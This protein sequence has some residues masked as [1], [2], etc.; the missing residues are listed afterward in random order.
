MSS[1]RSRGRL[2]ACATATVT[3]LLAACGSTATSPDGDGSRVVRALAG[4]TSAPAVTK[5]WA[6]WPQALHDAQHSGASA[7]VGPRSGHVRWTR[8]LEGD[9]TP[10][11]VVG[12][13]GTVYAASNAGVLHALDPATGKDRWRVDEHAGYG[14]DL[15]TSPAVLPNGIVL[16][17]G[18]ND[19]LVAV[20]PGGHVV[21]RLALDGQPTSP[22]VL[23]DGTVAVGTT[24]GAVVVL[25]PTRSGP[26]E[27][28]RVDLGESSYGSVVWSADRSTVYQS[29]TSGVVAIRNGAVLWRSEVGRMI[30]V[31][32]A[33]APDGT[34]V[35][36]TNDPYEYGL[37]P[38]DGSVAWRYDRVRI[39]YSSP[40]VTAD[41]IAYFGDHRN[42]ITGV[43]ATTG[44]EVFSYQGSTEKTGAGGVGIWTSV[45]VDASHAVYVGTRQGL[46]YGVDRTG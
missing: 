32:P 20:D 14:S 27:K 29:V 33:V 9:V 1:S 23:A 3:V 39:T 43:D 11:P 45:A 19:S 28:S 12:A 7:A 44:K 2:R 25:V 6:P 24:R 8:K 15:S 16:W 10:G 34:V 42:R 26:G 13:D 37:R 46:V 30:E 17:P 41:G 4:H 22:A 38:S 21:W 31:S 40:V 18:P 35:V 36:G 5:A